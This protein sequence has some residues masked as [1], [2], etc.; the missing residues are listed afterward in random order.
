MVSPLV[1]ARPPF[2]SCFYVTLLFPICFYLLAIDQE[3]PLKSSSGP[4]H[5][6][7]NMVDAKQTMERA[8]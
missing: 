3:T 6:V 8:Q 2:A 4:L 5:K 7:F 1:R